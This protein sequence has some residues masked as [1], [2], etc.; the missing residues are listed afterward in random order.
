MVRPGRSLV[1]WTREKSLGAR[2]R[3]RTDVAV[4]VFCESPMGPV[5][6]SPAKLEHDLTVTIEKPMR[7]VLRVQNAS[8][9]RKARITFEAQGG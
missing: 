8:G 2:F 3:V 5:S 7:L 1:V 6:V 9:T 4:T